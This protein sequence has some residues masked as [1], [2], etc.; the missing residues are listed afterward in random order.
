MDKPKIVCLCGSTK[1]K[2]QYIKQNQL[3]TL[4]GKVSKVFRDT[5]ES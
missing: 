4:R 2:E 3:E 1:F 5:E